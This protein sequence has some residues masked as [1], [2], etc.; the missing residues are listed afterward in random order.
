MYNCCSS[1]PAVT[2]YS[3]KFY[4]IGNCDCQTIA[5]IQLYENKKVEKLEP[6]IF[7]NPQRLPFKA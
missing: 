3:V 7:V 1:S 4:F 5:F 6:N 2:F